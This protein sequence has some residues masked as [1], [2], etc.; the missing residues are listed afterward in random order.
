M[1]GGTLAC[2]NARPYMGAVIGWQ[3]LLVKIGAHARVVQPG[4]AAH[5]S[6]PL[7]LHLVPVLPGG[8]VARPQNVLLLRRC[9]ARLRPQLGQYTSHGGGELAGV[10]LVIGRLKSY[11]TGERG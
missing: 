7:G 10:W 1:Q 2:G 9:V 8:D 5:T 3:A 6:A 4:G 11:G